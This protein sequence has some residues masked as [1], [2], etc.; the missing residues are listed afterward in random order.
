MVG[1]AWAVRHAMLSGRSLSDTQKLSVLEIAKLPTYV[2]DAAIELL[3]QLS[4]E[5][6]PQL[7]KLTPLQITT[8]VRHFPEPADTGYLLYSG[9]DRINKQ[10]IVEL[11]RV[12]D[13]QSI[14]RWIPDWN[15]ISNN[16]L[17]TTWFSRSSMKRLIP[18]SPLL[19][20]NGDIVF[21]TAPFLIRMD[22]CTGKPIW[23]LDKSFHHSVELDSIGNIVVPAKS[24]L[25][26]P[27]K[28]WSSEKWQ[29]DSIAI[30]S[31][32]GTLIQ[33]SSFVKIL[34][35]NNLTALLFGIGG[36]EN[37]GGDIIHM[38]Q[39]TP[40]LNDSD[41]WKKHDLL[42][43]SRHLST[44]F[45]YRP[46]TGKIIWH[47]TGPW[48]NQHSAEFVDDHRISVFSNNVIGRQQFD[49]ISQTDHN[50]V[51]VYDFRSEK[52]SEPFKNFL[53]EAKPRTRTQGRARLLPDGGL[54]IE[55]SNFG[56]HLRFSAD[57]LMWSRVNNYDGE[58]VA[59][60]SWSRYLTKSEAEGPINA[61][62]LKV[63]DGRE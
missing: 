1:T 46:S 39:I 43:S 45:L 11:I 21:Q 7:Q 24:D 16:G 22:I 28:V 56:R 36:T 59:V 18:N 14:A 2:K 54:F 17:L 40:A 31:P 20:P 38:N 3:S 47:Q 60:L 41:F 51:V 55:E 50:T 42:I 57:G 13:G 27:V 61:I 30:V 37:S 9:I 8:W 53:D 49:F 44:V 25:D 63:C 12:S 34:I 10:S 35:D 23:K 4:D 6:G 58:S 5:P 15:Y 48:M 52:T 32:N 29:D 26:F 33:N 19:M 62:K